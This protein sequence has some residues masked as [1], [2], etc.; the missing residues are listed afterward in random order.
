MKY[1]LQRRRLH[2]S[3]FDNQAILRSRFVNTDILDNRKRNKAQRIQETRLTSC[4]SAIAEQDQI[5]EQ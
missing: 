5:M 3:A 2:D 4:H 1:N